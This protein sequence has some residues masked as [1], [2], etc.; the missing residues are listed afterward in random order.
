MCKYKRQLCLGTG[1]SNQPEEM[2]IAIRIVIVTVVTEVRQEAQT[3]QQQ[4][5]EDSAVETTGAAAFAL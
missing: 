3:S 5:S 4:L 2:W 1:F